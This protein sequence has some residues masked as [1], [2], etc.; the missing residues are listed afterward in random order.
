M[1]WSHGRSWLS[2]SYLI[3]V[4]HV[5]DAPRLNWGIAF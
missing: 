1:A 5:R 2:G 4:Y 3:G